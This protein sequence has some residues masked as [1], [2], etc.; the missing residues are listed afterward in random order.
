[1]SEQNG[2]ADETMVRAI[3]SAVINRL[4]SNGRKSKV[5]LG[6]GEQFAITPAV[7]NEFV[8]DPEPIAAAVRELVNAPPPLVHVDTAPI[9]NLLSKVIEGLTS[10]AERREAERDVVLQRLLANADARAAERDAAI[11]AALNA[12][13]EMVAQLCKGLAEAPP[14]VIN[15]GP[16]QVQVP[17]QERPI[18]NVMTPKLKRSQTKTKQ[19]FNKTTAGD[20]KDADIVQTTTHEYEG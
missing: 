3:T 10:N 19:T 4:E 5:R 1:M 7:T 2:H 8:I 20:V 15:Q 11:L 12:N 6:S 18:V 16:I 13:A 17:P 9:A 14:P